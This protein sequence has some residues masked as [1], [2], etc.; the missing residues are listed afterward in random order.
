LMMAILRLPADDR[1]SIAVTRLQI[2]VGGHFCGAQH[3]LPLVQLHQF[4]AHNIT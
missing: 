3:V 2:E 4:D 1:G